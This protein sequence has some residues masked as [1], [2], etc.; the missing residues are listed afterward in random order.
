M[1]KLIN[2]LA[3]IFTL[4]TSL[5]SQA[6]TEWTDHGWGLGLG[7]GRPEIIDIDSDG[8]LD[9]FVGNYGGYIS[10]FEQ[11][12]ISS[13]SFT[14]HKEK[15]NNIDVGLFAAPAF[16]DMDKDGLLDL[17][18]GEWKG[19][20]HHYEQMAV[21][22]DSF[23]LITEDFDSIK[24]DGNASPH[25]T[26]LDQDGMLDLLIGAHS[27]NLYLYEQEA[28]ASEHF[29][30]LTDSLNIDPPTHRL[31]PS[32]IDLDQD[33]L[34]DLMVGGNYGNLGHFEQIEAGSMEF[35]MHTPYFF[36]GERLIYG[37]SAPCLRDI[38]SDGLVDLLVAEMDGL[39]YHFEQSS[40]SSYDFSVQSDNFFHLMDVGS[41]A[42]PCL[43]DL[44]DDGLWDLIVGEWHGNLNHFEQKEPGLLEFALVSDTLGNYDVGEFSLP[45]LTD[46]DAD[47]LLDLIVG[48]RD[49]GLHH[50]EQDPVN[51]NEFNLIEENFNG[52]DLD[53][54]AA[55]CFTDLDGDNLIDMIL[56]ES[57]GKLHLYEQQSSM[58]H[59]FS[60]ITDSLNITSPEFGP[61]PYV[62]DYD[63]DGLIDLFVGEVTGN[64][65]HYE[66][67]EANSIDFISVNEKF[68][69][70]DVGRDARISMGDINRD[71]L[72]DLICGENE[73]GLYLFVRDTSSL[74]GS[75]EYLNGNPEG[76]D[77]I[78]SYPNPFKQ[79]NNIQYQIPESCDVQITVYNLHGQMIKTLVDGQQQAGMHEIHWD[80]TDQ[81]GE[82]ISTGVYV[83]HMKTST[84][85]QSIRLV[86][87][88]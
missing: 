67:S 55:P 69:D 29:I 49:G 15:W 63:A 21:D 4:S 13:Y 50:L 76:F 52:I 14:L 27:G 12:E 58:S 20:L 82:L 40:M 73:G 62:M 41:G 5:Y 11:T 36:E 26:D 81:N 53:K 47:G 33:G 54:Y 28:M 56:G 84:F 48:D 79:L 88:Q 87:V 37:G 16:T 38:D 51:P 83:L 71:G 35:E 2:L 24:I 57:T 18:I 59:E 25:F 61:T 8:L 45:A 78:R 31:N 32:V 68:G 22:A 70:I 80:A 1:K 77:L 34:L 65:H 23:Q 75:P 72:L 39:F 17:L 86:K 19:N 9:L 44:D 64:I 10:H 60:L 7:N 74:V 3:I 42:S 66:Q 43:T 85:S 6:F 30:L 46:L